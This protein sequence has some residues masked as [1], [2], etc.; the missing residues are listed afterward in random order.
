MSA[1]FDNLQRSYTEQLSDFEDRLVS[2]FDDEAVLA[3]IHVAIKG[4]LT[5]DGA[6]E[7]VIREVLQKRLVSGDLRR[8]SF[9][10]VQTMLDRILSENASTPALEN[11]P[12]PQEE[13]PYVDTQVIVDDTP[14]TATAVIADDV[15][16]ELITAKQIQV[17]SVLRDRFLLQQQVVGGG[18]GLVYKALD[19]RLADAGDENTH[20]AIKLLPSGLSRNENAL[21]ALQQ[22][23]AKGRCLAHPNIVRFID[24]DREDDLYFIVME[25]LEGKSLISILDE[26]TNKKIDLET[27]LDIIKQLSL[28]L[29]YAHQRGVVHGD[30]NPGNVRVTPEGEVKLFDFGVARILQKEQDAQPDLDPH[31]LGAKSPEYSSMQVL[32]GEDPVPADDVFS[33]GC[34]MYRLIA[35]YRVFGPRSA[36]DAA[37][38]GMEPQQLPGL[39]DP[40]WLALKK[41]LAYSRVPR[42]SSPAEFLAAF[43]VLPKSKPAA[44][45]QPPPPPQSVPPSPPPQPAALAQS[46]PPPQPTQSVPPPQPTQSV[47]PSPPPQAAAPVQSPQPAPLVQPAPMVVVDEPM[48]AR[49]FD[50][51]PRRSPWRLATLGI[52]LIASVA[53]GIKMDLL[54]KIEALIPLEALGTP[55]VLPQQQT[56]AP[57]EDDI[58]TLQAPDEGEIA[59]VQAPAKMAVD[60]PDAESIVDGPPVEDIFDEDLSEEIFAESAASE[61]PVEPEIDFAA[62]LPPTLTLGLAPAGQAAS[63]VHLTLRENSDSAT[64]DLMRMQ[65]M[66]E[67]YSVLLEEVGFSGNRSPWEEGQ[68]EIGNNGVATFEAGQSRVRTSISMRPDS[69]READREVTIQVREIDNAE[70]ELARINLTLEDDDRRAYEA[71][72]P[73]NTVAFAVS[74]IFVSEADPA[75]QIDV[76]RFKPDNT[77][78]EF[79][80]VIGDINATAGEDYFPPGLPIVYFGPGQ[81][82][83]RIL[84]PLVQDT[85]I[86]GAEV[87][88]LELLSTGPQV[89]PDI[90]QRIAVMIRDD[91]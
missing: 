69:L 68:Y 77:A 36:A 13:V 61:T 79:S 53:A 18:S 20:V 23:V 55:T 8:E 90:Y 38:E 39:S 34:L 58:A 11:E 41:A 22:E 2:H 47:P 91:D 17:G 9:E 12:P 65:N 67:P 83:A 29:E 26:S 73:V 57:E 66:L 80:Y 49:R 28:A 16:I 51:E 3:E 19:Q 89:D 4:L 1:N 27:T 87:F 37:S 52:I 24:L 5:K 42:F 62:L 64:I 72:L 21:R 30:V 82:T 56:T 7:A 88:A 75:V 86:E 43:G 10:L 25:W 70:S 35:G 84:I 76:I 33:L 60:E 74:E 44:P 15:P 46:M 48:V 81:R 71:S 14:F 32:T 54:E 31:E 45:P 85:D 6:S 63:E 40:Q 50:I 59:T 78:V